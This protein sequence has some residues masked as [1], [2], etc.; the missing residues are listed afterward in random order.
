MK[1][2]M[3]PNALASYHFVAFVLTDSVIHILWSIVGVRTV[4]TYSSAAVC[5]VPVDGTR[6]SESSRTQNLRTAS[7]SA[8]RSRVT[9]ARLVVGVEPPHTT[10]QLELRT[11][12]RT[13]Y[14]YSCCGTRND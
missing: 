13:P 8:L 12:A 11:L 9:S 6:L 5:V 14:R 3:I 7:P 2:E 10:P 1:H 4:Y